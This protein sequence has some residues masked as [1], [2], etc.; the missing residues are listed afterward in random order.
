MKRR[1]KLALLTALG[2]A[3]ASCASKKAAKKSQDRE[4]QKVETDT[5]DT[6]IML[7]Y[8]VPGPNGNAIMT[9]EEVRDRVEAAMNQESE[10]PDSLDVRPALMYGVRI[11][12]D[13]ERPRATDAEQVEEPSPKE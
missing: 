13:A 7:M 10:R 6:H 1:L 2:F 3:T 8:G 5:I 12:D 11:P 4:S 9:E